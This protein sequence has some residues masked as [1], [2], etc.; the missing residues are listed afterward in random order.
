MLNLTTTYQTEND[1]HSHIS[2]VK[3]VALRLW[4]QLKLKYNNWVKQL[5]STIF[6]INFSDGPGLGLCPTKYL[7]TAPINLKHWIITPRFS[8]IY[9]QAFDQV[10]IS[11]CL[12][13][14]LN[15]NNELMP[16]PTDFNHLDFYCNV[17]I[18]T[19]F[20]FRRDHYVNNWAVS[21]SPA[22]N[23]SKHCTSFVAVSYQLFVYV[24]ISSMLFFCF[25][26]S[27]AKQG[28]TCLI[29]NTVNQ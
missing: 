13:D 27:Y 18:Y 23:K 19:C 4:S 24:Y 16:C 26:K 22:W 9:T 14:W 6:E 7:C 29:K 2:A 10:S 21:S 1:R 12:A 11:G 28:F 25:W 3:S 20:Y 5:K 15:Y 8:W 17:H